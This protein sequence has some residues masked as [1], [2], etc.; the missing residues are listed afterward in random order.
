MQILEVNGL[1]KVY[2]SRFGGNKV[3]ALKNVNGY[4]LDECQRWIFADFCG[5]VMVHKL[6]K[7]QAPMV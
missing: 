1:Q 5:I 2:T 3:E 7:R 6:E 4:L